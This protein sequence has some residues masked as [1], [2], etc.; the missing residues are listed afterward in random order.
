VHGLSLV[1]DEGLGLYTE[2][3]DYVTRELAIVRELGDREGHAQALVSQG[4][5][6]LC[7]GD[8]ARAY[9]AFAQAL[10]VG[11]GSGA[12]ESV[13]QA[14]WGLGMVAHYQ[15]DERHACEHAQQAVVIAQERRQRRSERHALRLLGHALA[16]LGQ[17]TQATIVYQRV[18]ELDR[19]LGYRH[20]AVETTA[21]LARVALA[22]A[23]MKRARAYVATIVDQLE[24]H[25]AAGTE[26]PVLIYLTC[27]QVLRGQHD[28]RADDLLAAG[29]ALLHSRAGQFE[30]VERR[31][32]FLE[33]LPS[34]RA[35]WILWRD[36]HDQSSVMALRHLA[37]GRDGQVGD[38]AKPALAA[39]AL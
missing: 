10:T 24:E 14:L 8:L 3:D 23:D 20:L 36:R 25:G 30:D 34:H 18:L 31:R 1:L 6:A 15:S 2:A 32:M 22:Q 11:Q 39:R 35:L 5:H 13:L 4:R 12:G 29:Y 9:A 37:V 27:Y 16:G 38:A 7:Q 28:R 19:A 33:N 17:L 21:D 26:Q